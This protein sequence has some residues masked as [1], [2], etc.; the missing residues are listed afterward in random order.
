MI[1]S[2][3]YRYVFVELPRTG[4]TAVSRELRTLYDGQPILY[5]HATY[6]EFLRAASEDEKTYF[7]FSTIRN[8][9]DQAVSR[10]YKLK[11]DHKGQF[12][13]PR[14]LQAKRWV[15]RTV[16][17]RLRRF[18]ARPD[19]DF[20]AYLRRYHPLPYDTWASVSHDKLNFV[21]RFEQLADDFD[22]A[23][24]RIGIEPQRRLPH[25]NPTQARSTDYT[26]YFP[27]SS[28]ARAR[29]V[30]GGYMAKWGYSFPPSWEVGPL[31][32]SDRAAYALASRLYGVYW[33]YVRPR[34][35]MPPPKS[36]RQSES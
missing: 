29:R 26:S 32:W 25:T 35:P 4:S 6:P 20:A 28:Y 16:D 21:M 10:F 34:L 18:A 23:L 15:N 8:P 19:A 14:R 13:D 3:R 7:A 22:E 36:V 31:R 33:L 17:K 11:T 12:S 2:H 27:P 24:R 9:L 1:I 30:F 5:K